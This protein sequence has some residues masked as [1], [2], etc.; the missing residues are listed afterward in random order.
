MPRTLAVIGAGWAGLA[1]AVEAVR[2]G[3]A[4][5]LYEMAERPGGRARE[6]DHDG[7]ALDNGQHILI[8][9]Y[10]QTLRLMREVGVD[11]D[12]VLLRTPLRLSEPDGRG[13]HLPPGAPRMHGGSQ[14][15]PAGADHGH[16][17]RLQR[18]RQCVR[19]A[20]HSLRS[21]VSEVRWCS[22]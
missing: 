12:A 7:L 10:A 19:H 13:L 1:A 21:G 4:V 5:T 8:G 14:A 2:A 22:T 17:Q 20:I 11:P 15:G 6:V 3:H 9:A 18:P 16:T